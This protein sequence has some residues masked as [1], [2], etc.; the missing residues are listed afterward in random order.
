[1]GFDK[2]I[3]LKFDVKEDDQTREI[4]EYSQEDYEA[5]NGPSVVE[6]LMA[7]DS[8]KDEDS[9]ANED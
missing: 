9:D 5:I 2:E 8:T 7:G 1:M 4:P 3:D 6:S